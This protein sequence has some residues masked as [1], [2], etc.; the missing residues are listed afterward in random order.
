M[1]RYNHSVEP[2][3]LQPYE[4]GL[5]I[6]ATLE[7]AGSE[8]I[9]AMLNTVTTPADDVGQVHIYAKALRDLL[10][11]ELIYLRLEAM[12]PVGDLPLTHA[13]TMDLLAQLHTT[14]RIDAQS[15]MWRHGTENW[16][17]ERSLMIHRTPAGL[18]RA[19]QVLTKRGYEWWK[20]HS[21][22]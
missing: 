2:A 3:I 4:M 6:L 11:H 16:R 7:E 10:E 12:W 15:S 8:A 18:E 21:I 5:R 9:A 17:T 13:E 19:R 20:P 1:R 14:M 22:R